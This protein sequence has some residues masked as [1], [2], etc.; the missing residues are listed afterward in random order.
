MKH[1]TPTYNVRMRIVCASLMAA[2]GLLAQVEGSVVNSSTG[3]PLAGAA[4]RILKEADVAYRTVAGPQGEFRIEGI[5]TGDYTAEFSHPGFRQPD[6]NAPP[7]R[8]FHVDA[9]GPA[10]RREVRMLPL[11]R[12]SGRVLAGKDLPAPGADVQLLMAGTFAGETTTSGDQGRFSF[13][14]LDPGPYVLSARASKDA[15][16]PDAD[17]G[18]QGWVRTYYPSTG[19]PRAGAKIFVTPGADLAGWDT[20]LLA[21]PLRRLSGRVL[22]PNGEPAPRVQV[23][24]APSDELAVPDVEAT[25]YAGDDSSFEFLAAQDR[26]W[27]LTAESQAGAIKLRAQIALEVA[28]RDVDRL[29]LRLAPPFS[30]I[31]KVVRNFPEG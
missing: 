8:P 26:W 4:I 6:R 15:P 5:A 20:H 3:R 19:D 22:A 30:L 29:Q 27:R 13:D 31:G 23:K 2:S 17:D 9:G 18:R 25:T 28:G 10:V 1:L 14:D 7:R 11:A 21:V 16:P 12:L 24:F